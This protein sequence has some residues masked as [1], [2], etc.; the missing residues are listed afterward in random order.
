M[1]SRKRHSNGFKAQVALEAIKNQ[2]TI[3]E[4]ASEKGVHPSQVN[5]W[6]KQALDG[7][8]SIFSDNSSLTIM[9][10]ASRTVK[11]SRQNC[12]SRSVS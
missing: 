2:N 12:I 8:P 9:T 7:L 5:K 4:I 11:S 6:K 1:S 3:A 10:M